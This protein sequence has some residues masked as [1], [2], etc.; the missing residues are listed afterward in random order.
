M[1]HCACVCEYNLYGYLGKSPQNVENKT[2]SYPVMFG[3]NVCH[4]CSFVGNHRL[5]HSRRDSDSDYGYGS[6]TKQSH[7]DFS[8]VYTCCWA[9]KRKWHCQS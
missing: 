2:N 4:D 5:L 3:V 7:A 1:S 9:N 8:M 6:G